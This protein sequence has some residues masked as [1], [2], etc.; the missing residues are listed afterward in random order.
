MH[1]NDLNQYLA[2]AQ[3]TGVFSKDEVLTLKDILLDG[4]KH[5]T[6][7]NKKEGDE[8]KGF[9]IFGRTPFTAYAWDIYWVV[10]NPDFQRQGLARQLLKEAE[11]K[12]REILPQGDPI[13]RIETSSR[14]EYNGARS[15]YL[16][17]QYIKVCEIPH[18]YKKNDSLVIF[19]KHVRRAE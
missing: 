8:L 6:V 11:Q 17:R 3:R 14:D 16:S 15:L 1:T 4:T 7:L 19:S 10:I 13:I 9:I 5:Y 12:M 2:C 18:F